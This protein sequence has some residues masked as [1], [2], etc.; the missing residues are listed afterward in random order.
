MTKINFIA[1]L[2]FVIS[3]LSC[4]KEE[5]VDA[6]PQLFF[7]VVEDDLIFVEGATVSLFNNKEDWENDSNVVASLQT[8]AKGQALFENL[9]EQTYYFY[10]E[11]GD[12]N[13]LADIAALSEP[14]QIGRKSELFVKIMDTQLQR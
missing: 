3:L 10:V 9:D 1:F 14:L 12:L 13:N 6:A 4:T 11:K 5:Y 7:T 2:A 8:D